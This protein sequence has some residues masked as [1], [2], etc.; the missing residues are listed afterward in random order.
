MANKKI[1]DEFTTG[2]L[3]IF[4]T[5][6]QNGSENDG[7]NYYEL[8][9]DNQTNV[10]GESK[11]KKYHPPVLLCCR[12]VLNA[13]LAEPDEVRT[14]EE[15]AVFTVPYGDF[16]QKGIDVSPEGIEKIQRGVLEFHGEFYRILYV[17][18]KAFV[19]DS[20]QLFDIHTKSEVS[21]ESIIVVN[22]PEEEIPEPEIPDPE[23]PEETEKENADF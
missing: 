12:A 19:E 15:N 16:L 10:Y 14:T 1:R 18:P 8:M 2:V 13:S 3:T 23:N 5:L 11:Y 6:L 17:N 7:L 21:P 22:P 20:F 4:N 9:E